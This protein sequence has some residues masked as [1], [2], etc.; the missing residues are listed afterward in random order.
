MSETHLFI[1]ALASLIIILYIFSELVNAL[2]IKWSGQLT[3]SI[4]TYTMECPTCH[5]KITTR[6]V[7]RMQTSVDGEAGA[8]DQDTNG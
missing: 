7:T 6:P 8:S 4:L 3:Q 1:L 2:K 5:A